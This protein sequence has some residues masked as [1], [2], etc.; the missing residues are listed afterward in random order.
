[1]P[2]YDYMARDDNGKQVK[3]E[4][5]SDSRQHAVTA[6]KMQKLTPVRIEEKKSKTL[7]SGSDRS[8]LKRKISKKHIAIF[9]RQFASMLQAGVPLPV[10]MD[11][12]IRQERNPSFKAIL[13]SI[14][15]DIMKGSTLSVAMSKF[16]V[17]PYMLISMVEIGEA[18]GRL[19]ISFERVAVNLEK[20]VKLRSKIKG[21]MVYPAVL[22]MVTI[23]AINLL[24]FLVL[25][26]FARMFEQMG[27][28]L[29]VL[30][31]L[32]MNFS[33]FVSG[34]WYFSGTAVVILIVIAAKLLKEPSFRR[35]FDRLALRIPVVG[36]L[37]NIIAMARFC[38]TFSSLVDG[39]VGVVISL[40][41]VRN[42]MGNLYIRDTFNE[43]I[44]EVKVGSSISNA[45]S[46]YDIFT[47]L[48]VSMLR[49]GEESGSLGDV[50]AKTA[51]LYE[52]E[53]DAQLQKVTGMLEPMITIFMAIGI[54]LLI[55]S[56]VQPMFQ[57]YNIVGK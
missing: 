36:R 14:N 53:A 8:I 45:S 16:K 42:I 33:K 31:V 20:E 17:F 55:I 43:I 6:L 34:Y 27:A 4:L 44:Q 24:L 5:F 21:A 41:T 50:L 2:V 35:E 39:G 11:I 7:E 10:I 1:M 15:A 28:K 26:V 22:L 3:G 46:K 40:E 12:L 25:P 18:N 54:G 32:L 9:T 19:D 29:P 52:D 37:M 48:V 57:M 30:T 38:R 23:I 56:I 51:E 49:I 13:D 47:P